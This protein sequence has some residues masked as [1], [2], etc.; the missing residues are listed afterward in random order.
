MVYNRGMSTYEILSIII[1][2]LSLSIGGWAHLRISNKYTDKSIKR[3]IQK[4][5]QN[6]QQVGGDINN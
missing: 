1:G 4:D 3:F 6:N 2:V 5:G